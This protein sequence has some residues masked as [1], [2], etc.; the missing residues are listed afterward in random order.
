MHFIVLACSPCTRL[1]RSAQ[2]MAIQPKHAVAAHRGRG[3]REDTFTSAALGRDMKYRVLL[4][5]GYDGSLKRYP[6]LFLLHGLGGNTT[7]GRCERIWRSTPPAGTDHRH[8]GRGERVVR[9]HQDG[10]SKFE[11]YITADLQLDVVK[12]YRTI[13]SSYGRAV[14][15][16]SMGATV[17]S[18][19]ALKRPGTCSRGGELQRRA[20]R[21]SQDPETKLG[22]DRSRTVNAIFG[23]A[24]SHCTKDNGVFM[25]AATPKPA[26]APYRLRSI[27]A[28][29]DPAPGQPDR[30]PRHW[31]RIRLHTTSSTKSA[32]AH[33]W[34]YWDRRIRVFLPLLMRKLA[35]ITPNPKLLNSELV[36]S[37]GSSG[38]ES[39][40]GVWSLKLM[41]ISFSSTR[42]GELG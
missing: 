20:S 10:A 8:A 5:N 31:R 39:E 9:G 27:A 7:T 3:L 34:D 41:R 4:P 15:G 12:K 30:S 42:I 23:A 2:L 40:L 11:D 26:N 19:M 21:P 16:L 22:R 36:S 28:R 18:K 13:N 1:H 17:L 38:F 29:T 32:G 25:F 6:V 14:A 33:T 35:K 24:D 37:R